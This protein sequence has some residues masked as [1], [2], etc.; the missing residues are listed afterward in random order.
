MQFQIIDIPIADLQR[1][2]G[3]IPGVH[4]NPRIIKDNNFKKLQNSIE[5]DPDM[6][7]LREILVYQ[8]EGKNFI[9]GGNMRFE[10]LKA[11]KYETATV[12]LIT[13]ELNEATAAKLNRIILKDNSAYGEWDFDE[14]SNEW[15]EALINACAIDVPGMFDYDDETK[16]QEER[17]I[18]K[19]K[20]DFIFPP[21][22]VLNAQQGEWIER[23]K[24]W[25]DLGLKSEQGRRD[26]LTYNITAQNWSW[27]ALKDKLRAQLNRDPSTK[28]LFA[29][30]TRIGLKLMQCTST[31]DPV[32]T[33]LMYRWFCPRNGSILDPFA[34]GSV[35][36]VVAAKLGFLYFGND[37]RTE[38]IEANKENAAEIF[39]LGSD[40]MPKWFCGDS[41]TIDTILDGDETTKGKQFDMI[42]SCPPYADLEV[43]SDDP[44]DISTMEY[45]EFLQV[46][47]TIINK[48]CQRL[49]ENRFAVFVVGDVRDKNGHYRNFVN[50]TIEAFKEAGLNYYNHII[51]IQQSGSLCT[52]VRRQFN[53]SRKVGK[54]HQNVLVFTKGEIDKEIIAEFE[55]NNITKAFNIFNESRK[56]PNIYDDILVFFKGEPKTIKSNFGECEGG[57]VPTT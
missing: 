54:N 22:S 5:E 11:L 32:L 4:K 14:L 10:A 27:Y 42:F 15:D 34:G 20:D 46:Y 57:N 53:A 30:A 39:P 44:K 29:E 45:D 16:A 41:A 17:E 40:Y 43:Y 21:F 6:L 8:Y 55:K 9:I 25:L 38:Q 56:T 37:L 49:K 23:K 12:K 18:K 51:Y 7:Q 36:G 52:R 35:R 24:Q 48:S 33:E 1:N 19:L 13:D 28:E 3:Q 26:S 2:T 50:D 47:K 31:F